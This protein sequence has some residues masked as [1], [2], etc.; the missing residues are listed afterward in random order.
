MEK[1]IPIIGMEVHIEPNTKSKMFCACPQDHFAKAA[2]TQVCPIC[3][4]LP[5]AL[6]Y[7]NREAILKTVR[8]GLSIGSEISGFSRFY[9]KN[10]FYPDL[11]KAFQTSQL[12]SPLCVGGSLN[13]FAINHIHLE[14]D[15]GKLVHETI[16]GE[17]VS[18]IDF[19][20]SGCALIEM[21]TEPVFHDIPSVTAFVKE[22]Q[23]I[24]RYLDISSAD[25]EKGS[26]R[27]EA[28]VSLSKDGSLPDYKVE[29][30]NI[31]SFKFLEKAVTAELMRQ[32]KAL[33][34]GEKLVQETRGYDEIKKTTYSQRTKSDAHDYRYFP[35]ADLAPIS[36]S[37][38][39][40]EELKT[41]L[42]ELPAVKRKKFTDMGINSEYADILVNVKSRA[43]YFEEAVK[44][45][46]EHNVSPKTIAEAMVNKK[47]DME[48]PEAAGLIKRLVEITK[49]DFASA[50]ET[51]TAVKSVII[52]Q[53]KAV[54]DY[55]SGNGNVIGF[56][57]GMVQKKLQGKGN[58]AILREILIKHLNV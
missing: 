17:K 41:A 46:G 56:L 49:V 40:I 58:P 6:P 22:L 12:D 29:L 34:D 4:G 55:K 5:G 15:A 27:L 37:K 3:L 21:V 7:A 51:E 23:L 14:E 45:G 24:A 26:M 9:R 48:F 8:L 33:K 38:E 2:N 30:K 43:E 57:I 44:V 11:P 53:E 16:E 1:F 42:P 32:E 19:N 54:N 35:E 31:N 13:G 52:E 39:E 25:M 10:Y 36:F 28:N 47:L 18:L 20:R 50:G